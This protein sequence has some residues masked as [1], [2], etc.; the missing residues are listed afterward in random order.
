LADALELLFLE[1]AQ[2]LGL[3]V[4]ADLADLV[5]QQRAAVGELEAAFALLVRAGEGAAFV[6]EQLALEQRF[7]QRGAVHA[8]ER[9]CGARG[10]GV[11][12]LRDAFLADAALAGDQHR[13]LGLG[14]APRR[15]QRLLHLRAL[16]DDVVRVADDLAAQ[17]LV[18]ALEAP[19]ALHALEHQR[20]RV[21]GARLHQEVRRA[22][23]HRAHGVL[24]RAVRGDDDAGQARD[25]RGDAFDE[26]LPVG[27][28]H[29]Q[30]GE[31]QVRRFA[32]RLF[33]ALG[34]IA[35]DAHLVAQALD[36][37][38]EELTGEVVVV[39]DED[40]VDRHG[41]IQDRLGRVGITRAMEAPPSGPWSGTMRTRPPWSAAMRSTSARPRPVPSARVVKN[42]S[43]TRWLS[44]RGMPGPASCTRS[45]SVSST[46]CAS[47]RSAPPCG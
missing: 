26:L 29:A 11:D 20:E 17:V 35:S 22:A 3:Q 12:H 46:C 23:L 47:T 45:S 44:A 4:G 19:R 5:E 16:G 1:H 37:L 42:G 43:S 18:L 33:E 24:D 6:A 15:A 9:A 38:D 7:R 21:G 28:R 34:A 36:G 14:D 30:V 40:L 13:A 27:A 8:D 39:D 41:W 31:H 10:L 25:L 32:A 2:Q